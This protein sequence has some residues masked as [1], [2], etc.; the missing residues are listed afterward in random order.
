MHLFVS[1][2]KKGCKK[3]ILTCF[4]ADHIVMIDTLITSGGKSS[5]PSFFF[6]VAE[7]MEVGGGGVA[8]KRKSKRFFCSEIDAILVRDTLF[9][10]MECVLNRN[11]GPILHLILLNIL[12]SSISRI[13]GI[14]LKFM[15][16]A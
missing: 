1:V 2:N 8:P 15:K 14:V 16:L 10:V 5:S 13:G 11:A 6:L 12:F 4:Y 3:N 7:K 9:S